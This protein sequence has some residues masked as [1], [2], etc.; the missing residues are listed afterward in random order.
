MGIALWKK[1][2]LILIQDL[3][4]GLPSG[5]GDVH[6]GLQSGALHVGIH[7]LLG[8]HVGP[9]IVISDDLKLGPPSQ[10]VFAR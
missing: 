7:Q 4:H 1:P 6:D 8:L 3:P 10:K 2:V 5:E 9:L